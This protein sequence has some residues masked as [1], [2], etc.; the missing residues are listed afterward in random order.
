MPSATYMK[1]KPT[2]WSKDSI[3]KIALRVAEK[4]AFTP[5]DDVEDIVQRFGGKVKRV[6]MDEL[7]HQD[8]IFVKGPNDFTIHISDGMG[9]M[10]NRFTI[11]HELGHYILHSKFG[12]TIIEANRS[13]QPD[14]A[15]WE[16]NWFAASFLMPE[17]S[18]REAAKTKST[19]E[20]AVIF[21]VS[22]MAADVRKQSLGIR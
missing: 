16:A 6:Q 4:L 13:G 15:E 10:R 3:E 12:E 8:S 14:R 9:P 7:V 21:Q 18:F 5:G 19:Q 20:L 17:A 2:G 22:P 11:A 1:P